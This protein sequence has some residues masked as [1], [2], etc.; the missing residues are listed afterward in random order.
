MIKDQYLKQG[1]Y[2]LSIASNASEVLESWIMMGDS[3]NDKVAIISLDNYH[4]SVYPAALN[5]LIKSNNSHFIPY[6]E[7]DK[8]YFIDNELLAEIFSN[9]EKD[10]EFGI[11]YSI[12]LDTNYA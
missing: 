8:L 2:N 4:R 5:N 11:D 6:F 3:N 12:M 10:T 9:Q 1:L 7:S